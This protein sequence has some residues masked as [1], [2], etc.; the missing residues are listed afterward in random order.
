MVDELAD[1]S[2]ISFSE[3]IQNIFDHSS[4]SIDGYAALQVY[5]QG[6]LAQVSVSDSGRG[7]MGTLRPALNRSAPELTRL[8]DL[9]LLVEVFRR[10]IS[11]HGSD[12]G[13][14]LRGCAAKAIKFNADLAV[15]LPQM[16]VL[17]TPARGAYEPNKAYC[18]SGMPLLWGTHISFGFKLP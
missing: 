12:R 7:I 3:L 5:P 16:E 1:A 13:C 6:N 11:R 17:L 15:R 9:H 10:G 2:W 14:G 18:T 4:T 8:D